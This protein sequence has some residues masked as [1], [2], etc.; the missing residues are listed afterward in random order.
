[1]AIAFGILS[2]LS[3]KVIGENVDYVQGYTILDRAF[4]GTYAFTFYLIKSVFPSGLSALHPMPMKPSGVLPLQ[5]YLSIIAVIGFFGLLVKVIRSKMN[6]ILK[7]DVLFGLLFF[8]FTIAL[9]LLIPVGQAVV[10][11]RYTYLPY[12]GIFMILGRL[13]LHFKQKNYPS[14]PILKHWYT[15]TVILAMVLFAGIT[16]SRN[17]VWKDTVSLFSDVIAKNPDAGLAYNN[18]GNI[19]SRTKRF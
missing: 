1:M 11:E 7:K 2:L 10:A 17:G 15:A 14:F 18:R 6:E 9:I 19:R 8:L 12:I 5:Y 16:Y 13:Y 4:L 3:Q